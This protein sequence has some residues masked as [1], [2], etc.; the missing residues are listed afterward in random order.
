M[1]ELM[2]LH[3]QYYVMSGLDLIGIIGG[4]LGVFIGFSFLDFL[5]TILDY[6]HLLLIKLLGNSSKE[7]MQG[8][9]SYFV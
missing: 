9:E 6:F 1:P 3:E 2:T 5:Y 7:Q 8:K 4:N